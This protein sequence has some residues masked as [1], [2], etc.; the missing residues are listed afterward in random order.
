M[1]MVNLERGSNEFKQPKQIIRRTMMHVNQL[2][3]S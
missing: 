1:T 3:R 2:Q